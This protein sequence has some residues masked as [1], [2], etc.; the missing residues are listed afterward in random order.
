MIKIGKGEKRNKIFL[1]KKKKKKKKKKKPEDKWAEVVKAWVFQEE[2][3]RFYSW[4]S[5]FY[6]SALFFPKI[7]LKKFFLYIFPHFRGGSQVN[8]NKVNSGHTG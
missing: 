1:T 6:S 2:G 7:F 4:R 5:A 3:P 8:F